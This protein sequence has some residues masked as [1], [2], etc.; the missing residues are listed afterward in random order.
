M[1]KPIVLAVDLSTQ[2]YRAAAT[3]GSL[4]SGQTFTGGLYGFLNLLARVINTVG[5][6]SVILCKDTKPYK[7]S[8]VYPEYKALRQSSKDPELV[9]KVKTTITLVEEMSA[10]IGLPVWGVPG[11]ESD[12]LIAY[13][14]GRYRTVAMSSDSDLF[15]LFDYP[16][17]SMYRGGKKGFY[18]KEDYDREF[19]LTSDEYLKMLALTGTHNEVEGIEGVGP[20]TAKKDVLDPRRWRSRLD[21][22]SSVIDRNLEL[23]KLPHPEFPTRIT[24]P[25]SKEDFLDRPFI[26][27]AWKYEIRITEAMLTSLHK[28]MP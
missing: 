1:S 22:H 3:H 25:T 26:R 6:D 5:P 10:Q 15:Q 23:V 12:D 9:K 17:F 7:R 21:Q 8:E 19:G 2:A 28:V 14:A 20:V 18:T 13:L 16:D 11:F 24:V 4:S 27:W